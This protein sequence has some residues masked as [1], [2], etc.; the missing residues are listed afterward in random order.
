MREDIEKNVQ[1]EDSNEVEKI[2]GNVVKEA[3]KRLKKNKADPSAPISSNY[4]I[5][6]PDQVYNTLATLFR[7]YLTHGY[8]SAV[9]TLSTMM[10]FKKDKL[11]N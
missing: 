11:G 2:T 6:A 8:I 10:P 4:F 1:S 9:L 5:D 3:S 7:S